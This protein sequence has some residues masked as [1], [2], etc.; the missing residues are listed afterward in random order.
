[1]KAL[2][3]SYFATDAN[4]EAAK[5]ITYPYKAKNEALISSTDVNYVGRAYDF[6]KAGGA[7]NGSM[8]VLKTILQTD[9]LWNNIRVRG[10]AY[11]AFFVAERSG[12]VTF[13]TYRDPHVARSFE[14]IKNAGAFLKDIDYDDKAMH[15]FII[16]TIASLDMPLPPLAVARREYYA[17]KSNITFEERLALRH[18]ILATT[19]QDIRSFGELF[20]EME[21]RQH[22]VCAMLSPSAAKENKAY[23]AEERYLIK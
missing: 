14:V 4:E 9:Y 23:F 18:E 5:K 7:Y 19:Q 15:K 22:Y 12:A 6:V 11:G 21:K 8:Q 17:Y 13:A 16:G 2:S 10:G 1:M 20:V 3:R